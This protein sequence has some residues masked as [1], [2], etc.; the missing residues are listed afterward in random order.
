MKLSKSSRHSKITGDFGESIV[1]YA[2]SCYHFVICRSYFRAG[3]KFQHG[4]C[5]IRF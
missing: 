3:V 1:L 4:R 5:P 2:C